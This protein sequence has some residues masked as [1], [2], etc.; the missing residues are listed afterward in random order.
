M[1][2]K[3]RH[4]NKENGL[5]ALLNNVEFIYKSGSINEARV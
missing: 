4:G 2:K 1:Y 3:N 5:T